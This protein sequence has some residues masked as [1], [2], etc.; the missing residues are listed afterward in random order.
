MA[1]LANLFAGLDPTMTLIRA[2]AAR[3]TR[4]ERWLKLYNDQQAEEL[5]AAIRQRWSRPEDF[6]L[7]GINIVKK[8]TNRRAAVYQGSPRRVFDRFDQAKGEALY[9]A[10]SANAVLKK[11]NRVVKLLKSAALQVGWS[12]NGPSLSLVPPHALDVIADDPAHPARILVTNRPTV[13]GPFPE[14]DVFYLDWTATTL[15][16]RDYAG[17]QKYNPGNPSNVNFYGAL[18]FVPLFDAV[19]DDSFFLPGG[20]DL[21]DAQL[22]VNVALANLW[23]AI[24]L[25]SHGQAWAS[26]VPV[27]SSIAVGPDRA[28]TL[29]TDGKFGF[30][31]PGTPIKDVLSAIEFVVKQTA[32]ANDLAANVFEIDPKAQ[33]GTA[34][35]AESRDLLEAREDDLELWRGYESRLFDVLKRVVNTHLPGTIPENATV[36]VDFAEVREPLSDK[37]RLDG[38]QQRLDMGIWSPVDALLADNPDIGD[39][40]FAITLLA[41]RRDER[42]ALGVGFAGPN[43]NQGGAQ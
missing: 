15:V 1:F 28:V 21:I 43:F 11:A 29:P 37:E 42:S 10:I 23:R 34:K 35:I 8:I 17:R 24:E 31:A 32:V 18:P 7:F 26:G 41:E 5:L 39:R 12:S 13:G 3:K 25:Q 22:A 33:S 27:G 30:A 19:P 6:R 38:Y 2:S 4:Q 14:R 40:D 36:R 9:R 16:R 20:D